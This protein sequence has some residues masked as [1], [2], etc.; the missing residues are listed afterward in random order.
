MYM[1]SYNPK[2]RRY[3]WA[4]LETIEHLNERWFDA[5]SH[6]DINPVAVAGRCP[7]CGRSLRDQREARVHLGFHGYQVQQPSTWDE[8]DH[9]L[10]DNGMALSMHSFVKKHVDALLGRCALL[11]PG[12]DHL[13]TLTDLAVRRA[14][15]KRRAKAPVPKTAT[16]VIKTAAP[17]IVKKTPP[18]ETE[19]DIVEALRSFGLGP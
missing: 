4:E 3:Y 7:G 19:A 12:S 17:G 1:Y 13:Q 5:E 8:W 6:K 16:H 15:R 14:V 2:E 18:K 9:E 10:G 11:G